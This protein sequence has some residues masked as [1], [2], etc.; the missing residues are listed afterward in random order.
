MNL[1]IIIHIIYTYLSTHPATF[2]IDRFVYPLISQSIRVGTLPI[3][4]DREA[5]IMGLGDE[6]IAD[7]SLISASWRL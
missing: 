6:S 5:D 4:D 3:F 2:N 7:T 1:C